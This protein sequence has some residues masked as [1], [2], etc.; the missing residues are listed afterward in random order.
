MC[1]GRAGREHTPETTKQV[2]SAP[3][4]PSA[5]LSPCGDL[6]CR[7]QRGLPKCPALCPGPWGTLPPGLWDQSGGGTNDRS[8]R[9]QAPRHG[10][11]GSRSRGA[12]LCGQASTCP[13][14]IRPLSTQTG[15]GGHLPVVPHLLDP[16]SRQQAGAAHFL[17]QERTEPL[18]AGALG[19]SRANPIWQTNCEPAQA[20]LCRA[21]ELFKYF[22][23]NGD[24][25]H[26]T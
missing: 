10:G 12:G 19:Q 1:R 2:P 22:F 7:A 17:L 24:K 23:C 4:D 25:I 16:A 3:S 14:A 21:G 9:T 6:G 26:L 5:T 11:T 8:Q 20:S 15:G 13:R 18:P